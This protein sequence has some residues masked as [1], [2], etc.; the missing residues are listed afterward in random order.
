MAWKTWRDYRVCFSKSCNLVADK[1]SVAYRHPHG[2]GKSELFTALLLS[3]LHPWPLASPLFLTPP[4]PSY[5]FRPASSHMCITTATSQWHLSSLA[6]SK[7]LPTLQL[8]QYLYTVSMTMSIPVQNTLMAHIVIMVKAK[9]LKLIIRP[10]VQKPPVDSS[11]L[12]SLL[13]L[14][15]S[16]FFHT[17][18]LWSHWTPS[19]LHVPSLL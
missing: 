10:A 13:T 16:S 5:E 11:S 14:P 1:R 12:T 7:A 18:A 9:F 15:P 6:S 19:V 8:V 3:P 4:K 2:S 17:H